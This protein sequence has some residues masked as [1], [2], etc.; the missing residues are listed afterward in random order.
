MAQGPRQSL[1]ETLTRCEQCGGELSIKAEPYRSRF[2]ANCT[3]QEC[4]YC[5]QYPIR[6]SALS[7]PGVVQWLGAIVCGA[8]GSIFT[9]GLGAVIHALAL[10]L[11]FLLGWACFSLC[12]RFA[13]LALLESRI[14]LRWKAELIAYLAP[15]SFLDRSGD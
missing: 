6:A 14:P 11:G 4:G 10:I 7:L 2:V 13:A 5:V 8:V 1:K 12:L 3:N 15:P 9:Q